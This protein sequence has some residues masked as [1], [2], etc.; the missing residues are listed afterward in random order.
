MLSLI[1]EGTRL[2]YRWHVAVLATAFVVSC[3]VGLATIGASLSF[4][5]EQEYDAVADTLVATGVFGMSPDRPTAYKVPGYAGF[6]AV[7]KVVAETPLLPKLAQVAMWIAAAWLTMRV[8]LRLYGEEAAGA[9]LVFAVLYPVTA[10]AAWTLYP[11]A[12]LGVLVVG[13]LFLLFCR[14]EGTYDPKEMVFHGLLLAFLVLTNPLSIFYALL[15]SVALVLGRRVPVLPASLPFVITL[16][17][18]LAWMLRNY[19]VMDAPFTIATNM[20]DN[21]LLGNFPGAK[22]N[23]G[24]D[25]DINHYW[26]M[27]TGLTEAARNQLFR[28]IA[29][30]WIVGHPADALSLYL[31]KLFYFFTYSNDIVTTGTG[32]FVQSLVLFVGYYGI[33]ALAL[34]RIALVGRKPLTWP[35]I[36][37]ILVYVGGAL[38]YSIFFNRIRFR[39]PLDYTVML[40]ASG[41]LAMMLDWARGD[42]RPSEVRPVA[43]SLRR[44]GAAARR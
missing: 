31:Q 37:L 29:V 20:G 15:V 17:A 1:A 19:L 10:F 32:S 16:V 11:Q 12:I 39:A 36:V 14:E 6:L 35:E 4:V 24:V 25:Q 41:G 44:Q 9:A 3:I 22:P 33:L 2:V 26:E 28:G 18:V 5:D 30:D 23:L 43:R 38:V 13:S 8:A 27:S 7:F 40:M 34:V 42:A 21:L